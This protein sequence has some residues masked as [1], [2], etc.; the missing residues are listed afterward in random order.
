MNDFDDDTPALPEPMPSNIMESIYFAMRTHEGT[1]E[2]KPEVKKIFVSM[3]SK[4]TLSG[5]C[6]S[7]IITHVKKEF[8]AI[9]PKEIQGLISDS[10][11]AID[12]FVHQSQ[13]VNFNR[14]MA[15]Y[16]LLFQ[17]A[18]TQGDTKT[19]MAVLDKQTVLNA[20]PDYA[21]SKHEIKDEGDLR[22]GLLDYINGSE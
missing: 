6:H 4:W 15:K 8:P 5:F 16:D 19:A 2:D 12:S 3:I 13:E 1:L 20:L 10:Q 14:T 22:S 17:Q 9:P 21:K 18:M 7:E 11:I